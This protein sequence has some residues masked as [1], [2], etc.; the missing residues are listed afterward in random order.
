MVETGLR[1]LIIGL[2]I[3][4]VVGIIGTVSF[5][6]TLSTSNYLATLSTIFSIIFYPLKN[7]LQL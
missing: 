3:A 4:F 7:Y 1:I 6:W 5:G 2:I